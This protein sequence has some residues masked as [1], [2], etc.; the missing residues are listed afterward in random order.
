ML[1]EATG[2]SADYR[3][4]RRLRRL[5]SAAR[6]EATGALADAQGA[7]AQAPGTPR[8]PGQQQ[9]P[10]KAASPPASPGGDAAESACG[11]CRR[12]KQQLEG[13]QVGIFRPCARW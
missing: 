11:Q 5:L 3:E 2:L 6:A 4:V 1:E 8:Q 10:G 13:L 12:L 9:L 7:P